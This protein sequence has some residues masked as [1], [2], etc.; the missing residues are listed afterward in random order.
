MEEIANRLTAQQ[1]PSHHTVRPPHLHVKVQPQLYLVVPD[2]MTNNGKTTEVTKKNIAE[3]MSVFVDSD[4]FDFEVV[5]RA[6]R[7][8]PTV[9]DKV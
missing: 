5:F 9:E 1:Q 3:C 2:S 8:N 6:S 4:V 7:T